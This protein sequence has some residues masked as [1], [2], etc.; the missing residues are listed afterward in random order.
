[1]NNFHNTTNESSEYVTE[2]KEK[3]KSQ[4]QI[5]FEFFQQKKKLSA[6][7]VLSLFPG[8]VPIT[9]IRRAISN[10]QYDNKIEITKHKKEGL[11]G[12]PEHYYII[13]GFENRQFEMFN[14]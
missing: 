7:E 14:N 6:S 8:N 1:M 13:S 11:Y 10:L 5:V 3:N 2:R 12:A 9:S 4:E